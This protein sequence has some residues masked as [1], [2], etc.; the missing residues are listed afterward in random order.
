MHAGDLSAL[1]PSSAA[2]TNSRGHIS[3]S[4]S[5]QYNTPVTVSEERPASASWD[6]AQIAGV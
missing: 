5:A 4:V 2:V 6:T 1:L 3:S